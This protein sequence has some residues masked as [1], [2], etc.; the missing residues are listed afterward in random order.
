MVVVLA[1]SSSRRRSQIYP[2]I[3][4]VPTDHQTSIMNV[5]KRL[6]LMTFKT[7]LTI[8]LSSALVR[9]SGLQ[10][11]EGLAGSLKAEMKNPRRSA[12]KTTTRPARSRST[13]EAMFEPR[14][15]QPHSVTAVLPGHLLW[16]WRLGRRLQWTRDFATPGSPTN[17]L[18]TGHG[19]S[20][21]DTWS[22]WRPESLESRAQ[23][24]E[25]AVHGS[26]LKVKQSAIFFP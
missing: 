21:A 2:S 13:P 22:G 6:Q 9:P 25:D 3:A 7:K 4:D 26:V 8:L 20:G 23:A 10:A 11:A 1:H 12:L 18:S 14:S 16:V 19:L 17:G 15:L 5:N 24:D